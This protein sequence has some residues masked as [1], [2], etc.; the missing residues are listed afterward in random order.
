LKEQYGKH[1]GMKFDEIPID[2]L[3][4]LSGIDLDEDMTY[5]VKHHFRI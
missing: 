5:T 1:K 3:E 4:W 2:Y